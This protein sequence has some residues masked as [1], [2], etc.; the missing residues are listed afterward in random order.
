MNIAY[1]IANVGV[2]LILIGMTLQL[3]QLIGR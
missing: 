3:E 2:L 1:K